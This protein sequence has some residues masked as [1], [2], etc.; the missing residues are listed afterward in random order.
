MLIELIMSLGIKQNQSLLSKFS[1]RK[2]EVEAYLP[3]S[4]EYTANL[5][6][7]RHFYIAHRRHINY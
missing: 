4:L 1:F 3:H 6:L 2:V 5:E 7:R